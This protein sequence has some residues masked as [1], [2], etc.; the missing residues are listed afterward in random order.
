LPAM[1]SKGLCG[2]PHNECLLS[3]PD[4]ATGVWTEDEG[5]TRSGLERRPLNETAVMMAG[6]GD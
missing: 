5:N 1:K 2:A 4:R 6:Y 3:E